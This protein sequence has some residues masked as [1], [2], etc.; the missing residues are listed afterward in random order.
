MISLWR[1]DLEYALKVTFL[2]S[3]AVLPI[4]ESDIRLYIISIRICK[5]VRRPRMWHAQAFDCQLSQ[6]Q[7]INILIVYPQGLN[8][9]TTAWSIELLLQN[10]QIHNNS[11]SIFCRSRLQA[12]SK[13]DQD[14]GKRQCVQSHHIR[15]YSD[16]WGW[17]SRELL[18][19]DSIANWCSAP[20]AY[21][22]HEMQSAALH[23]SQSC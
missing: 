12:S 7:L 17:L 4:K 18:G 22:E 2:L 8:L 5:A 19:Q 21:T 20:T 3:Q 1:H 10:H 6:S 9:S 14:D 16:S 15:F 13:T 11:A 23:I